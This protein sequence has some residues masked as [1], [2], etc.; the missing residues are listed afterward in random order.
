M[1]RKNELRTIRETNLY[2][3]ENDM[4]KFFQSYTTLRRLIITGKVPAIIEG[5]RFLIR[6]SDI[7]A[8]LAP[9]QVPSANGIR[10]ID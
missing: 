1:D 3:K 2:A 9:Q 8:A 7:E 5:N 10:R 4:S 6:I